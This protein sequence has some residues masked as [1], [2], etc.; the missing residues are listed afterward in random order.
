[1]KYKE[2]VSAEF[3]E[4]PNRFIAYVDLMGV[5]TKVHVKN[6]GRCRELLTDHARV[7]LEKNG[8]ESR[9]TAYD[10]VAVEKEGRLVNMDSN[11]PNRV[12]GEWLQAGGLYRDVSLVRPEKTF[13]SS[14]FDFY[15]E[16]ASGRRAYIEV[17][18]VTLEREGVAAFPD[19]PSE[20]AL[21]HVEELIEARR[22]GYEAY[23]LFVI[24]M[25]G[26]CRVE[27]NLDTQPAFGEALKL[28]RR[29]G[30]RLLAYDCLVRE[31]S[32]ELDA[33]VPVVLDSLDRIA[34]PLLAWYDAGRR[35]LPW[36]EEPTPYHVW[37]SEIM[38]Q[39]TRVEAVKPYYDRFLQA[40]P[41]IGSLAAVEEERLLKLWE[42]LGY[43][44][45][46]RNLKKAAEILVSEY[47]G[48]MPGD[49]EK[50]Q[51]L[52]GIGSYTAGA[53]SS[54]AFGRPYPAVDGNVLRILSRLRADD[55]DILNAK[56]KKSVEDE[57]LDV[58]PIDRPGDFNQAL[59]ELGAM[60][61]IPN[62]A[63]KC[64]ECPW[65]EFCLARARE[66]TAEFPKKAQKKPRSVEKKTILVI[67]DAG[68]V[69]LRKRPAKG[70]L[71]GM[72]EFPS[73]EGHCEEA[74]VSAY[75]RRIGLSPI[76]IRKLP[77]AKHVF[78]HKEWHMTGYL[79]RVDELAVKGEGQELQ[80][81]VFVEPEQTMTDYPIPSAFA[82]YA[83]R[84]EMRR[85]RE[86]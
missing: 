34:E 52:P 54:I 22:Q 68:R 11:A 51:A 69:A 84:V 25:K 39:Q 65:K 33:P 8:K 3:I 21:K 43:Y 17:K 2:I 64:E 10:L 86:K 76:R 31:D 15:V 81:F 40:L 46:A 9:A 79:I 67:Q 42:G 35:I 23:L 48:E 18:G 63:P 49:Y 83:E 13:G 14:R 36:R 60:V 71:A 61:C 50:I 28:A 73:L 85:P 24:Q 29:E 56:V 58:M 77:S 66:L 80:G 37:L 32:L 4:R 12:A 53:I 20:R 55:R 59:M 47:G 38:L 19:A 78:T 44:N 41:D 16:S 62:G 82:A 1:M 45:R 72:Y 74:E 27:P 7:Y 75:L 5:R 26:I 30:V 57:L 6:T 70:L